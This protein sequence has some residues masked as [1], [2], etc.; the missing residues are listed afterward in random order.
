[1]HRRPT[2]TVT[3]TGGE[4]DGSARTA[5]DGASRDA[6]SRSRRRESRSRARCWRPTTPNRTRGRGRSDVAGRD[7]RDETSQADQREDE[8]GRERV[9]DL[10]TECLPARSATLNAPVLQRLPAPHP[11]HGERDRRRHQIAKQVDREER[12]PR[13]EGVGI[14]LPCSRIAPGRSGLG[15][16]LAQVATWVR[17][18]IS[19]RSD[20]RYVGSGK[21]RAS[22][23]KSNLLAAPRVP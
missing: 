11:E 6:S 19:C 15:R 20:G 3:S 23:S 16:H 18:R 17:R 5:L 7:A 22:L 8:R 13:R 14:A 10:A 21:S 4:C 2:A 12:G 9:P 1:M